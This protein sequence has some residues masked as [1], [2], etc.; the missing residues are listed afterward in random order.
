MPVVGQVGERHRILRIAPQN[1]LDQED[2]LVAIVSGESLDMPMRPHDAL[3]LAKLRR[4]LALYALN[5]CGDDSRRDCAYDALGNLV[6]ND[7]DVFERTVVTLRP[8]V[9]SAA[10]ID[11]LRSDAYAIAGFSNA[12]FK[13]IANTEFAADLTHIDGFTLVGE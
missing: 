11:Q 7:K 13:H 9:L 8:D 12:S 3:P 5:F 2:C 6:L 10:R 1:L 4:F